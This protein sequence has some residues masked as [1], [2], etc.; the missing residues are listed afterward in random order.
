MTN[1]PPSV[2]T[3]FYNDISQPDDYSQAP[4]PSALPAQLP[5]Q[6]GKEK[7]PPYTT[8]DLQRYHNV[9]DESS[10]DLVTDRLRRL[11]TFSLSVD[12][13]LTPIENLPRSDWTHWIRLRKV[14]LHIEKGNSR[15][16]DSFSMKT[17]F[18]L[19]E[20]IFIPG[21]DVLAAKLAIDRD[22]V[23]DAA[24]CCDLK[25]KE[26]KDKLQK[27]QE[28]YFLSLDGPQVYELSEY[29]K[30]YVKDWDECRS[31]VDSLLPPELETMRSRCMVR[32]K[33]AIYMCVPKWLIG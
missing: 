5:P 24:V 11:I 33:Y 9:L 4:P 3:S 32:A 30:T 14:L 1:M 28:L 20:T 27:A 17:P 31:R 26:L 25:R 10:S 22:V 15:R 19:F 21:P 16:K 23:I 2:Q 8:I 7:P 12:Y 6:D 29:G 18:D 13:Q